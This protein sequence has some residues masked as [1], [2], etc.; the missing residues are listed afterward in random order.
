MTIKLVKKLKPGLT[1]LLITASLSVPAAP[2][3]LDQIVAIVNDDIVLQSELNETEQSIRSRLAAQGRAIPDDQILQRQI[4]D[5]LILENIQLQLGEQQGI[6]VSDSE[7]NSALERIASR[8]GLSLEQFRETLIAEGQN[9]TEARQQIRTEMLI[10]KIQ[11]RIVSSRIR[12]SQQEID[13]FLTSEQGQQ[14]NAA[15]Y[16]LSQ[17]LIGVPLQATP[18]MIQKA[19]QQAKVVAEQL[20]AGAD[21]SATAIAQ[22]QGPNA[23]KG[24]DIGWR[25]LNEI[26]EQFA[27]VVK[28]L[29]P[30]QFSAPVR[31]PSGFH[32]LKVN[33]KQGSSVQLV[34]QVKVRH[35][36]LS[37]NEIRSPAQTRREIETLYQRLRNGVP[38]EEIAK[39]YSDDAGSGSQGG[40]LGWAQPGQMVPEFE[41]VMFNTDPGQTSAPFES[42]FGWHILKVEDRRQQDMGEEMQANQARSSIRQRKYNE[43]LQNWLREIRSQAYIELK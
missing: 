17:I 4:L 9:Y 29:N 32:I 43:E 3:T 8:S 30:G 20:N 24:G 7:L 6:R 10:Q 36:L 25:K 26:P 22:S 39:Q 21:F 37:P 19:E 35:I 28:D 5:R 23:L 41:Q 15:N 27:A 42:R 33:D 11:Q 34:E 40:S 38:F 2:V 16:R 18:E 14:Q 31:S 1:A 12:V 13:N